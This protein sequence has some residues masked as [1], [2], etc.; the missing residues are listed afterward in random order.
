MTLA[1]TLSTSTSNT[2]T[3]TVN[4]VPAAGGTLAIRL[5]GAN[6]DF[7]NAVVNMTATTLSNRN[8]GSGTAVFSFGEIHGDDTSALNA[9]GGG[10]APPNANFEIGGL[11]T[12]SDFAGTINDGTGASMPSVASL[13]KI[14]AGTLT[15]TAFNTYTGETRVNDGT[16]SISNSY[17]SD[18]AAVRLATN[19]V[20]DL[21]Y[22]GTD[23]INAL[24]I[25]GFPQ[26]AGVYGSI[27]SGATFESAM[28]TGMGTLTVSSLGTVSGDYDGDGDVD[29]RD[30]LV[31]Q[32]GGS[33]T[34]FSAGDLVAWQTTYGTVPPPVSAVTAV[35][36][37]TGLV[38]L[39]MGSL[40]VGS[41]RRGL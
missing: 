7:P 31:W 10:S 37:P 38:L 21:T 9:F 5:G 20:L 41:R 12:D 14:G 4:F 11:D 26:A 24:F 23:T 6:N 33:P 17:L 8:G 13:T 1:K 36:E 2:F 27:G 16:L 15:L 25:N 40:F 29:G 30:F 32:R 35:P 39:L 34:P 28:F 3:G 18:T 22:I 19:A